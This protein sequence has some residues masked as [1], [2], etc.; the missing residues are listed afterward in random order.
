MAPRG[1]SA[2][3]PRAGPVDDR[4]PIASAVVDQ[5]VEWYVRLAARRTSVDE[6]DRF[7]RWLAAHDDHARVWQRLQGIGEQVRGPGAHMP[8]A[9]ARATMLS[10]DPLLTR[11]RAARTLVQ[12]GVGL[13]LAYVAQRELAWRSGLAGLFAEVRTATGERRRLDL[14]DGTRL[15]LNTASAVDL[16]FTGGRRLIR[17]HAGEI[18]VATGRESSPADTGQGARVSLEVRTP[19]GRLFPL[20]TRFVARHDPVLF[21]RAG[22]T[23]LT[24]TEGIVAV[25]PA[26]RHEVDTVHVEAGRRARFTRHGVGV[27]EPAGEVGPAWADGFLTAERMPLDAFLA[28]VARHRRGRLA[29]GPGLEALRITGAWPL[30][31][32]PG[33]EATDRI[34][35]SIE[36]ELPVR[37][38][39]AGRYWVRIERR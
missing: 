10:A 29:A 6:R 37:V 22:S 12:F 15:T 36:R 20:G 1:S 8:A 4:A 17:L 3:A 19:E 18:L 21:D 27:T 28:E 26:D 2:L 23:E 33:E 13:S 11:R 31:A 5:A 35:A 34:L 14:P 38:V 9:V 39:S 32:P 25:L 7:E 30:D 16:D 24:V